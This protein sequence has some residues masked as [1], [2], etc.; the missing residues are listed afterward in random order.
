MRRNRQS[1]CKAPWCQSI[2]PSSVQHTQ[3]NV[4]V[5]P[6]WQ[7]RALSN[8]K[9]VCIQKYIPGD[10]WLGRDLQFKCELCQHKPTARKAYTNIRRRTQGMGQAW[11]LYKHVSGY[12]T[13]LHTIRKNL[14]RQQ[15][16]KSAKQREKERRRGR[17]T[18]VFVFELWSV[19]W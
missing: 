6:P 8:Q 12:S 15:S 4:P 5:S 18:L 9:A 17:V 13:A 16:H 10:I 1:N 2:N 14:Q 11:R 7:T 19:S 3:T